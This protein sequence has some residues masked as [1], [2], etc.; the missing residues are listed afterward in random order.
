MLFR[1]IGSGSVEAPEHPAVASS[2]VESFVV[3]T[4]RSSL[5]RIACIVLAAFLLQGLATG[6]HGALGHSGAA[7]AD[8]RLDVCTSAVPA[9]ATSKALPSRSGTD[10]KVSAHCQNCAACTATPFALPV[11]S[12]PALAVAPRLT[13]APGAV[14][15]AT[16]SVDIAAAHP[17][18][19]PRFA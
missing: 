2:R 6:A 13:P 18:G 4:R 19:P 1:D 11:A 12:A 16:I 14:P 5:R 15:P 10:S 3:P 17:R 7:G 8:L 9:D